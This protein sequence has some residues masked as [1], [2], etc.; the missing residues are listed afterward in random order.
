MM[1]AMSAAVIALLPALIDPVRRAYAVAFCAALALFLGLRALPESI[2]G[3]RP[4]GADENWTGLLL[5]TLGLL[6]LAAVLVRSAGFTWREF[7]LT[8]TQRQ[9]TWRAALLIAFAALVA[10]YAAMMPSSFRLDHVS[11][12]TWLYQATAPGVAEELAFR[13]VL[14][15]L[16]DRAFAARRDVFGA[17]IGWG[18][19]VVTLLFVLLHVSVH[20]SAWGLALGVLPAALLYLWLR[21]RSGSLLLPILVHNLWNLSVYAA[22]L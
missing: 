20:T 14:L 21:A 17:P 8:S 6:I 16:A 19:V 22:H 9:G 11:A 15:A 4:T 2:P 1:L 12:E 18:G 7:G 13:G 10:N 3:L 5:A